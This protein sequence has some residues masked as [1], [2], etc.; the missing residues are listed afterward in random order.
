MKKTFLCVLLLFSLF[1]ALAAQSS[2]S[3]ES[4][5][6]NEDINEQ[7]E[8]FSWSPVAKAKQYGVTIEKWDEAQEIWTDFKEVKTNEATLEVLFTPGLYRVSICVY[9]FIGRKSAP[10]DWVQF[11][12]L[13]ENV[14]YLNDK[15]LTKNG[16]WNVPVLNLN[17]SGTEAS[18]S[19]DS[20]EY[21]TPEK[22][23]GQNTMLVKGRNIFSPKTE[24][25]LI[26]KEEGE[27]QAFINLSDDRRE[28][29]LNILYRNS[30]E[31]SVVVSYDPSILKPG[32]YS[33]EVRNQGDNRDSVDILV[34]DNSSFQI[35]PDKGF[36][37]DSHYSVNSILLGSTSEYE[38]SID[39][40]GLNSSMEFY[41]EPTTGPYAYPFE[42][43][44]LR[45]RSPLT[46]TETSKKDD[47]TGEVKLVC[48]TQ[49]LRTGY[50]NLVAKDWDG[51]ISKFLC[52][53]KN[54]FETDYTK[55]IKKLKSK[56]NK[57]TEYV[58]FSIQDARFSENKTYTLVSEYDSDIDSNNKVPLNLSNNGKKL[59]AKLSPNQ[60]TFG[61]YALMIEDEYSSDVVYCTIDNTLKI[62]TTKMSDEAIEKAFFRTPKTDAEVTLDTDDTG[63]IQFSDSKIEMTKRMPPLFSNVRLDLSLL[64]DN[65][66]VVDA[67]IDLLNFKYVSLAL[68]YENT[69]ISNAV[70]H[71]MFSVLR[72]ELDNQYFAPYLGAGIG[73]NLMPPVDGI[74][75]FDDAINMFKD[76]NQYY[77]TAQLGAK[78]LT[79]FDVRYNLIYNNV[80]GVG[81]YF[82]ERFSFGTTFPIRNYKFK[83][84]VVTQAAQISKP[85]VMNVTNFLAPD[86]K[87]DSVTILQSSSIGGFEG[88]SNIEK[89]SIDTTVQIIDENAFR[90]CENLYSVSFEERYDTE[91]KP[92]TIKSNAFAGDNL[93]DTIYLPYRTSVV[94]SGAFANWTNGQN[95]ILCWNEDDETQRDLTGLKNCAAS[96]HYEN[97]DLFNATFKTPLEDERNWVPLNN[98][99]IENVSILQDE[100]YTLGIRLRGV[101]NKWYKTELDTWINQESSADVIDFLKSGD[102][103]SFMAQGNGNKYDVIL[104][105]QDGGYFY[106]RFDTDADELV[107]V[108]VPYKKFKK[109]DYSSQKKLDVNNIKMF[110]IMPMCKGE[111]NNISF[112]DFEVTK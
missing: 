5:S 60:L 4:D 17:H 68:G 67:E 36:E 86:S 21:I 95:I 19:A 85:G 76:K 48:D 77:A 18:D 32:Y 57:K 33:L 108:E 7:Y 89:V 63:S 100:K 27:G 56:F 22:D 65:G 78:I 42:T 12:I 92:L 98:L 84:K 28:Q 47:S 104:T 75:T 81:P 70:T 38:I 44:M 35:F 26:P 97:G 101:G 58:D 9:N 15:L 106:Y 6:V 96:V 83:R 46:I 91:G 79:I 13:E 34:V 45:T 107:R 24:F 62:T 72:F 10:S 73:I 64:E 30:K 99:E 40:K 16:F 87:V 31:Y 52:L 102:T 29:K 105:T 25:Y 37:I 23:F 50:Y 93:I 43:Q 55:S 2:D 39:G 59:V 54:P 11:K 74:E 71:G 82:T 51:T 8:T 66:K 94:H 88:F 69:N 112:F 90:G 80:F 111:W 53:V 49:N 41:F 14:P 3:Y 61:K 20:L 109:Y 103:L 110:C 1:A